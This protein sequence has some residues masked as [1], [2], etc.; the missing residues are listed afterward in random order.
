M[1]VAEFWSS[2]ERSG[3]ADSCWIWA[4][5]TTGGDP[6]NPEK[7]YGGVSRL[8]LPNGTV[9]RGKLAHRVAYELVNGAIPRGLHVLH[10]CEN[11]RCCNPSHLHLGTHAENIAQAAR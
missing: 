2:M 8:Q 10:T 4:R 1:D 6:K 11:S 5:G 7:Q 3:G 9:M